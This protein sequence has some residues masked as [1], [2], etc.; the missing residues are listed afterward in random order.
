MSQLEEVKASAISKR[1]VWERWCGRVV[2]AVRGRWKGESAKVW[3][4]S[5]RCKHS[6]H[7]QPGSD[8][9]VRHNFWETASC[10]AGRLRLG[11]VCWDPSW[12]TAAQMQTQRYCRR[13]GSEMLHCPVRKQ[14]VGFLSRYSPS[15][16]Q[17]CR[18]VLV[19]LEDAWGLRDVLK[20]I[21]YRMRACFD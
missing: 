13:S 8:D 5:I 16:G 2:V 18:Y 1:A 15:S 6:K 4:E 19:V 10:G 9:P 14:I 11:P 17:C 21:T 7:V 3:M 20:G 12:T